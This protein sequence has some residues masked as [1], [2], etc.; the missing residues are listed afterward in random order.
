MV[1]MDLQAQEA[2]KRAAKK[3]DRLGL[4]G[5]TAKDHKAIGST[6][7]E[8]L[9]F[10]PGKTLS[11]LMTNKEIRRYL[12]KERS[13]IKKY[14]AKKYEKDQALQNVLRNGKR[15]LDLTIE[16]LRKIGRLPR[17]FQS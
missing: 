1:N 17:Q 8:A 9:S 13:V 11:D 16:Y 2:Y 10:H 15:N 6:P 5:V 3:F 12:T 14:S 7:P 4:L